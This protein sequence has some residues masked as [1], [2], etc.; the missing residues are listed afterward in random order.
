MHNSCHTYQ[1]VIS[2]LFF[3]SFP[4]ACPKI[5]KYLQLKLS[6]LTCACHQVPGNGSSLHILRQD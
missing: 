3:F 1:E 5:V 2:Y 4:K 6:H